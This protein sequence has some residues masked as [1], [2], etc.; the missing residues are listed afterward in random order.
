MKITDITRSSLIDRILMADRPFHGRMDLL[1]FLKRVWD[2]S[3]MPSTDNRFQDAVGDIWQHMVNNY[4]WSYDYLLLDRL[5]LPQCDDK[6]FLRFVEMCVHP[7]VANDD[8]E[9]TTYVED[10]NHLLE[11]DGYRLVIAE[12]VSGRPI[13]KAAEIGSESLDASKPDIYEIVLSFAGEDRAYVEQVADGLVTSGVSCFYDRYEEVTLW[14]KDLTEHLD[15][16]YRS[17]RYCEMFISKYYA[18][19]LWP[20]HERRSALARA[21]QEKV[22]YIL[23]TRFDDTEVPGIR[24]TIGYVDLQKKTP[25]QL[26]HMILKKLG[27][28]ASSKDDEDNGN[29]LV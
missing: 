20:N 17:A 16:V 1:A 25:E 15:K 26:V 12:R 14:G 24:H 5:K 3:S 9:I 28:E 19:K 7:L 6:I 29:M 18:E 22:E 23:P 4:D 27:R 13:Y 8:K 10:F 21:V 2:L 11:K